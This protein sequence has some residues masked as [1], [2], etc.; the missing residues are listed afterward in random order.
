M[1]KHWKSVISRSIVDYY[2]DAI[3][4]DANKVGVTPIIKTPNNHSLISINRKTITF[5]SVVTEET[6]PLLVIEFLH[7]VFDIFEDYFNDNINESV[8][9]ENYV[10]VY[11]LLDEMLDNGYPLATERYVDLTPVSLY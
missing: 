7:R 2:F 6:P 11:E 10:I 8:I 9:K 1:E 4:K 3:K 5:V